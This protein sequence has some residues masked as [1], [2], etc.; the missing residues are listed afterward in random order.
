MIDVLKKCAE[1]V[2]GLPQL[3]ALLKIRPQSFYSWK[4]VPAERVLD[5]ERF[6]GVPRYEIRPDLYPR[7]DA[8]K[9]VAA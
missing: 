6:T 5:I 8:D 2:E 9:P 3:A 1:R 4:K 7:P